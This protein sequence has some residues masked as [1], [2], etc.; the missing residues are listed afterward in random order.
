MAQLRFYIRPVFE[1]VLS[2][3][4]D[5]EMMLVDRLATMLTGAFSPVIYAI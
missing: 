4:C 5:H 2:F 1:N 3:T